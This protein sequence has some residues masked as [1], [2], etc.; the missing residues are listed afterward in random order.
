MEET[1]IRDSQTI[2]IQILITLD[3]ENHPNFSWS[4][5]QN[6][7][8]NKQQG[9]KPLAAPESQNRGQN[10]AQPSLPFQPQQPKLK[11]TIETMMEGF[12]AAQQQQTELIK[13]LTSRMDELAT[14]NKMLE[15]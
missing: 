13:Q 2:R 3:G 15:N 14:Y 6:Q 1:S 9:Y 10:F 4:N 12:L 7:P 5:K 8:I 11:I